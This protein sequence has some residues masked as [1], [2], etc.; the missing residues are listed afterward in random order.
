MRAKGGQ[1]QQSLCSIQARQTESKPK[2]STEGPTAKPLWLK[3][4]LSLCCARSHNGKPALIWMCMQGT[5]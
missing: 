5:A 4:W 3:L 1:P 2:T